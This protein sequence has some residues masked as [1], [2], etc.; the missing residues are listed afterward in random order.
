MMN[1]NEQNFQ[2]RLVVWQLLATIIV[3]VGAIMLAYGLTLL[4]FSSEL[5][6]DSIGES[7]ETANN[8]QIIAKI[9]SKAGLVYTITGVILIF[10]VPVVIIYTIVKEKVK[11]IRNKSSKSQILVDEMYDGKDLELKKKGYDA[12]SVKKLRL[13]GK[14]LHYDYSVLN[15]VK[16]NNMILITEDPENI[17]GC[18]ENDLPCIG[19][20][21]NPS[22]EDI[23]KELKLLKKDKQDR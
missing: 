16:E 2:K 7:E 13:E 17:G 23:I 6:I 12:H 11:P 15:Y 20:G 10:V 4:L 22:V 3:S 1:V 14:S 18:K 21:Q 8:L 5:G 9:S 19:L